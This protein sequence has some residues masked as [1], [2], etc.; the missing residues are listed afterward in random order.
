ML[1][2]FYDRSLQFKDEA[3]CIESKKFQP[4][5]GMWAHEFN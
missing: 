2:H 3:V 5:Q 4:K 1:E